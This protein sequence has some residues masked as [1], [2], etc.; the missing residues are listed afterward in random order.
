[1]ALTCLAALEVAFADEDG[2]KMAAACRVLGYD[3]MGLFRQG[4]GLL[5]LCEDVAATWTGLGQ[6][7]KE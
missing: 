1:M 3:C 4:I 5:C 6:K 7:L 2:E